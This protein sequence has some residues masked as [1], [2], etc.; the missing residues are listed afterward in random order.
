MSNEKCKKWKESLWVLYVNELETNPLMA[1]MSCALTTT[2]EYT[3]EQPKTNAVCI[4]VNTGQSVNFPLPLSLYS[5]LVFQSKTCTFIWQ[6][7]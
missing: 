7:S 2:E 1:C 6:V 5:F 3:A 4:K